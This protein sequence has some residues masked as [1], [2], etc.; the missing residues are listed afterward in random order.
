MRQRIQTAIIAMAIFI[1]IVLY[2]SWP[3]LMLIY[4]IGT[5]GLIELIRMRKTSSR[6]F[7]KFLAL[8]ILWLILANV[9]EQLFPD[10]L[11]FTKVKLIILFIM[12]L[13]AYTVI[14]KNKFTIDDA[15]FILLSTLYISLGFYFLIEMRTIGL[16][17][18]LFTLFIIWGTDTG[19]YFFG[20]ALG[21][22]KLWP[23]ISPN[24]TIGGALGGIA[25]ACLVGLVFQLVYPFGLSLAVVIT[26]ALLISIIGQI[27]DLVASSFK[28]HYN[29]K[30]SSNI[31]P[32]HG[33]ILD[34]FDSL[35]FVLPFLYL[36]QFI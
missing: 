2:G 17:Y 10:I 14:S 19:A 21:K 25:V 16:N 30:D 15:G 29:V 26:V 24:K 20:R 27:G 3:F 13:L 8:S 35:L 28:R 11:E 33:G 12:I 36:I 23:E 4:L 1:P 32:G 9:P 5:I 31:L 6:L 18:I 7:P 22:R 34:R